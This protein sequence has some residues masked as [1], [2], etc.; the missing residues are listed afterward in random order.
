MIAYIS[1]IDGTPNLFVVDIYGKNQKQ[2]TF[3][4]GEDTVVWPSFS[5]IEDA[6]AYTY[7][8]SE[9]GIGARIII[10]KSD[11][12]EIVSFQ[13]RIIQKLILIILDGLRMEK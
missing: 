9:E 1:Y 11:G 2:L 13:L 12:T 10:I 4:E 6:I 8:S 3:V 7:N 5:P